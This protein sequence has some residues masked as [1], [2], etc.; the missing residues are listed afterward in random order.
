V[1]VFRSAWTAV[2]ILL[3]VLVALVILQ[4]LPVLFLKPF[5]AL[6]YANDDVLVYYQRGDEAGAK[7]VFDLVSSH[8][9]EINARLKYQPRQPLEI[10]VYKAQ[11]SLWM[12][13]YGLVTL[14]I[15]PTWYV[16]DNQGAAVKLVSPNT[17]VRG[18]T[19]DSILN[20]IL[21]E[22][23]HSVNYRK[24]PRLSYFWNNG[25]A[26]YL[27][28]QVPPEGSVSYLDAPTLEQTHTS[29]EIQ[30]G[31]MGGYFYSYSYIA[32]LDQAYG[33]D[34]VVDFASGGK[35]YE[36]VFGTSEQAIYDAWL[37]SLK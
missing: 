2:G 17:P 1:S 29:N 10:F 7:E 22:V 32:Y 5:G 14:L 37:A 26:T 23:V 9:G 36:Q 24:N 19:H 15:A 8:I 12:R 31:E 13:K 4:S 30:F 21:H 20:A 33:W 35:T 18:H 27:A 3:A 34:R 16:G 6:A 28:E 25:L 11:S